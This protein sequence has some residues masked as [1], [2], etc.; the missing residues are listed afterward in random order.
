MG[1]TY[2]EQPYLI[3][4][5]DLDVTPTNSIQKQKQ[6]HNWKSKISN[7]NLLE[8]YWKFIGNLLEIGNPMYWKLNTRYGN[9]ILDIGYHIGDR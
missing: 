6:I 7:G 8:I 9:W 2:S 3:T 1:S 5:K 4:A